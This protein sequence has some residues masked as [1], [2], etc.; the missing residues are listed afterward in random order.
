MTRQF[1]CIIKCDSSYIPV[2]FGTLE[3]APWM[4]TLYW[5]EMWTR[6]LDW[7]YVC[8]IIQV[9]WGKDEDGQG[10]WPK[11]VG[12]VYNKC[13]SILQLV[14]GEICVC[15]PSFYISVDGMIKESYCFL[16]SDFCFMKITIHWAKF[17][18]TWMP[19]LILFCGFLNILCEV[20]Q[21]V[22]HYK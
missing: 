14:G 18:F 3:Y 12:V 1:F 22:K 10:I 11:Y 17:Q 9:Q 7:Y 6:T 19:S 21:L 15:S 5:V 4:N 20:V 2:C 16:F 13:K 8:L